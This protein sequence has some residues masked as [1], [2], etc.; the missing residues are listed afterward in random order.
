[1]TVPAVAVALAAVGWGILEPLLPVHLARLGETNAGNIGML[2]AA[3]TIVYGLSTPFVSWLSERIGAHWT[4]MIGMVGMA[5][6]L[7]LLS[8][9]DAFG[10]ILVAL[11]L[12]SVFFALLINPTS[13]EL[14]DAV[15]RRGMACY[16]AV[17]S[18]YNVAYGV[19]MVG[20]SSVAAVIAAR[21]GFFYT[22]LSVSLGLLVCVP[23]MLAATRPARVTADGQVAGG[24]AAD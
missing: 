2:F 3:A 5:L 9:S 14:G 16:A 24:Q 18:V 22:L 7:P 19:G 17:Y 12:F 4:I 21:L 1:M 11:C 15:E 8:V 6:T 10:F 20:T 23:P 13:A